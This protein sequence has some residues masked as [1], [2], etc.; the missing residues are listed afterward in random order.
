MSLDDDPVKMYEREVGTIEPL[1]AEDEA[2]LFLQ[3]EQSGE[4]GEL[5]KRRLIESGLHLVLPIARRYIST[6]L[7]MLEL[8]QE[9]NIG[10]MRAVDEFPKTELRDFSAFAAI[11]I[12]MAI[13]IAA[14]SSGAPNE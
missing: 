8:I 2:R 13:S 11:R 4:Q 14:A 12:E 3:A 5:A 9:G 7:S 1:T 6:S 10:L